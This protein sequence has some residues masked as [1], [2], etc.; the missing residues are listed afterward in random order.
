MLLPR[1]IAV[2]SNTHKVLTFKLQR[3]AA[4]IGF[5]EKCITL[6]QV[7][8]FAR[9]K[10]QFVDEKDRKLTEFNLMRSHLKQHRRNLLRIST[11]HQNTCNTLLSTVGNILGKVLIS[12]NIKDLR[13][14]NTKQFCT[15]NGKINR[16]SGSKK[17][18]EKFTVPIINLSSFQDLNTDD[19]RF[20]LDYCFVDKNKHIKRDIAV[21]FEHLASTFDGKVKPEQK[22]NFH[23]FLRSYCN[24]FSNNIYQTKDGTY[25]KIHALKSRGEIVFLSGDKDSCVVIMNRE[26]YI[27]KVDD[28][29]NDGISQGVYEHTDDKTHEDLHNFR[30][31][32]YNNFKT[33]PFYNDLWSNK[34]QPGRLFC[35]AKT[36]KFANVNDITLGNLKLRPIIDQTN[37]YSSNAAQ[38]LSDYLKPLQDK[39]Y[40]LYDTLKFPDLIRKLPPKG[41]D[42][43]DVSYDVEALFTNVPINVTIDY[44]I[45]EIYEKEVIKP[46]CKKLTFKRLLKRLTSGG[47][48]SANGKLIRQVD[49]CP[50]GG[51]FSMTMASICMTKCIREIVKPMNPKF[52]SLYVD[53][54]FNRRKKGETDELGDALNNFH[55]NLNFTTEI[56]PTKFLDSEFCTGTEDRSFNLR[57]FHKPNKFPIHWSS[58]T[59]RRYKRNAITCELHRA[60]LIADNFENEVDLIR[61]RYQKAGFPNAFINDVIKNFR[62]SRLDRLIPENFFDEKAKKPFFRIRLPFCQRNERLSKTF[63]Q[64]LYSFIGDSHNISI[65]WN[66]RKIRSLFP[67]KDKN[68]HP[69]CVIYEGLCSCGKRYMGETDRCIHLRIEEHENIRKN[70]EPAKHLKANSGH[71]FTWKVISSA[72]IFQAKRKI[73]EALFIAKFKPGLN[74]QLISAKL[75]VFP[76]GVT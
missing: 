55:P 26:D 64:K 38:F 16:L 45:D 73:L 40:M 20:G 71:S 1:R 57:V 43:E 76:N 33:C 32:I 30:T 66:T 12:K 41:L 19:L 75:K 15:K 11:E 28:L 58:Q 72:P 18:A 37:S 25:K 59:P 3:T 27:K 70:S 69:C 8:K 56:E 34:N 35:T 52:F 65:I 63:L 31:F 2:L 62:F 74:E 36:H 9:I 49:G 17:D 23:E 14:E 68:I 42:E 6:G 60:L 21:E 67:L 53:D 51:K 61:K 4:S 46:L 5:I 47:T 29:I 13:V 24:R 50:I 10:G 44:I 39:E 48:F 54:I 22:E 7:P